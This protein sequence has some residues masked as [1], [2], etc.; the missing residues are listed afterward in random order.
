[1]E[2]FSRAVGEISTSRARSRLM[3]FYGL[4]SPI[5]EHLLKSDATRQSIR[6]LRAYRPSNSTATIV[7][8]S[9]P[10]AV[11]SAIG[12]RPQSARRRSYRGVWFRGSL[13]IVSPLCPGSINGRASRAYSLGT[14][15]RVYQS[16]KFSSPSGR[17]YPLV[18]CE[19]VRG[20]CR[21][22]RF[23][24]YCGKRLQPAIGHLF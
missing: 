14:G 18:G 15:D 17:D 5:R 11:S 8:A 19:A 3:C 16:S 1:M 4:F 7:P 12:T 22:T 13:T 2:A 21:P 10:S 23:S 9:L 24:G 6:R 20:F